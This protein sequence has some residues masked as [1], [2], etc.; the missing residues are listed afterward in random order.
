MAVGGEVVRWTMLSLSIALPVSACGR[1]DLGIVDGR[2]GWGASEPDGEQRGGATSGGGVGGS[3][4]AAGLG[5][6][7][8]AGFAGSTSGTAGSG[9]A[10]LDCEP[11][12]RGRTP[13]LASGAVPTDSRIGVTVLCNGSPLV[14]E[15]AELR[16]RLRDR[17]LEGTLLRNPET[18][19]LEFEPA[20]RLG[21]A[22]TYTV[23]VRLGSF[24]N[25]WTF[26]TR[27]GLWQDAE[28]VGAGAPWDM[29]VN[30][31]GR[32]AVLV[33]DRSGDHSRLHAYS[34]SAED[35]S[36]DV[37]ILVRDVNPVSVRDSR[38]DVDA[39]GG[40]L[41]A[42][43]EYGDG[44]YSV[45]TRRVHAGGGLSEP[46]LLPHGGG[47]EQVYAASVQPEGAGLVVWKDNPTGWGA[48]QRLMIAEMSPLG[49]LERATVVAEMMPIDAVQLGLSQDRSVWA[50]WRSGETAHRILARRRDE[51][52][53]WGE[54]VTVADSDAG[55]P[56]A[57]FDADGSA[58][59]GYEQRGLVTRR[60]G[61]SGEL[62]EPVSLETGGERG[63][64]Y[65]GQLRLA[66][67]R[68]GDGLSL[69]VNTSHFPI[70]ESG[71][72][73]SFANIGEVRAQRL[74]VDRGWLAGHARLDEPAPLE[75]VSASRTLSRR[76]LVLDA[77]GNGFAAWSESDSSNG[78][79]RVRASRF[80][81]GAG[82]QPPHPFTAEGGAPLLAIDARGRA[83]AVWHASGSTWL[84]RFVEPGG[85]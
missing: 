63:E 69:W 6:A 37:P 22:T 62:G 16:V 28:Y 82:F 44:G 85:G 57:T 58:L 13:T 75:S 66:L 60:L 52:G 4:S 50:V 55:S 81:G 74:L 25:T 77:Q 33:L 32:G 43:V 34:V 12:I 15:R 67:D 39:F 9:G 41:T 42:W 61:T 10:R 35:L 48:H 20:R 73:T 59:V 2:A 46:E 23:E 31:E 65:G 76:A 8:S 53:A 45:W 19:R 47:F 14:D 11:S 78:A 18:G 1:S 72:S 56:F 64:N 36:L 29:A 24:R 3:P 70:A 80:T 38:V 49:E 26:V 21:L 17:A 51:S 7:G 40:F 79:S 68:F 71:A 54:T 30:D 27:D 83:I 5:G 84:A